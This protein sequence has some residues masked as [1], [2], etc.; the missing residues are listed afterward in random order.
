MKIY[1]YDSSDYYYLG[2]EEVPDRSGVPYAATDVGPP[3]RGEW[4][5]GKVPVFNKLNRRWVFK[6][7][8]FW[9]V[10]VKELC[11]YSGRDSVEPVYIVGNRRNPAYHI[12]LMHFVNKLPGVNVPRIGRLPGFIS[13]N[14]RIDYIDACIEQIEANF[15]TFREGGVMKTVGHGANHHHFLVE[16]LVGAIRRFL[17]DLVVVAFLVEFKDYEPWKADFVVEGFS[18]LLDAD[19]FKAKFR[20]SFHHV[21]EDDDELSVS[22]DQFVGKVL[23]KNRE[24]L[25]AIRQLSNSYKHSVTS[26]IGRNLFGVDYPTVVVVGVLKPDRNFRHL[27]YHNHSLRQIIFGV[28]DYLEDLASRISQV[29]SA[30]EV[31]R[32]DS[33]ANHRLHKYKW[34]LN[35]PYGV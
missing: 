33:C 21:V 4:P 12:D 5:D 34:M 17:D 35:S 9:E 22:L 15:L 7:N 1:N 26:N 16:S 25:T 29:D 30:T 8:D 14:Q 24:F 23:G 3:E 19:K 18:D 31:E 6:E 10:E 11:F 2:S 28:R 27:T 20:K 13:L 32:L